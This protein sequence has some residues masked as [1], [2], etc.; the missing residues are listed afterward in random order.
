MSDYKSVTYVSERL[1]P[2]CPV[3]TNYWPYGIDR[4]KARDA[5]PLAEAAS[6]DAE[7]F[8]DPFLICAEQWLR[9]DVP[10]RHT[11]LEAR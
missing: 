2:F 8:N 7:P 10:D 5:H 3:Y 11:F 6:V 4:S 9:S 1:L